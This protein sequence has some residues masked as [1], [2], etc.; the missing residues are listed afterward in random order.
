MNNKKFI[1]N[2][3]GF[4][5]SKAR[6]KAILTGYNLGFL[7]SASICANGKAF[8]AAV[9]EVLPECSKLGVGV[10]LN[11]VKGKALTK[12]K[13]LTNKKNRFNN[14]F[15]SLWIKSYNSEFLKEVEKEFRAQ[16]EMVQRYTK[17]DH[18]NSYAHVHSI[19]NIFKIVL[20][21][22]QEYEI[23]FIRTEYEELY[24]APVGIKH[25]TLT[26]PINLLKLSVLNLFAKKNKHFMASSSVVTND[27]LIGIGYAGILDSECIE[28]GLGALEDDCIA[29]AV[30]YPCLYTNNKKDRYYREFSISRNKTL[31]DSIKRMGFEITNYKK[32]S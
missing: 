28:S 2:A 24:F 13:T 31:E 5:M 23:P 22:A 32:L 20:K 7:S 21:L 3:D 26:Y 17:I 14:N 25:F 29:E 27:Y 9:N 18:I 16:I 10:H 6:N 15:L 12:N 1:L 8:N 19:P 30:I 4:G 11:I